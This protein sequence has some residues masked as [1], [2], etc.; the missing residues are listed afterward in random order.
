MGVVVVE[1]LGLFL[2]NQV[3]SDCIHVDGLRGSAWVL[4][5][6]G[7]E[8]IWGLI[9]IECRSRSRVLRGALAAWLVLRMVLTC[10]PMKPLDKG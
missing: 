9:R 5:G 1:L 3:N 10:H 4:D 8:G 6:P 2:Q 7:V